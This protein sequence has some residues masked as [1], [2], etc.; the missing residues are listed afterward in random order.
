MRKIP[1]FPIKHA[2][3][4]DQQKVE[5]L[6]LSDVTDVRQTEDHRFLLHTKEEKCYEMVITTDHI[7]EWISLVSESSM[8]VSSKNHEM[9]PN[10]SPRAA[11]QVEAQRRLAHAAQKS[12]FIALLFIDLDRMK[13]YNDTLGHETGDLILQEFALRLE[14]YIRPYD[15]C[16]HFSGDQFMIMLHDMKEL[17]PVLRYASQLLEICNSPL[18]LQDRELFFTA[19]IGISLYSEHGSELETLAKHADLALQYAKENG[20]N[21]FYLYQPEMN[22]RTLERLTIETRLR[23]ALELDELSLEYQPLFSIQHDRLIG[24]EALLRWNPQGWRNVQPSE[25]IPL[26]EETGLI[27]PIGTWVLQEACRQTAEWVKQ[28]YSLE[29]SVN[30]SLQQIYQPDFVSIVQ[31]ALDESGLS[32]AHLCLE[33]TENAASRN[34]SYIIKTVQALKEIGV[35]IFIDDFGTGYSSLSYIK[36]FCADTIKIDRSF[37]ENLSDDSENTAIVKA[38]ITMFKSLK[39]KTLAEGVETKKQLDFLR[40]H[41]CDVVQGYY[42]SKP[43]SVR[44]FEKYRDR[45]IQR[46]SITC[47]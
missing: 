38:L 35:K 22:W 8:A 24:M 3:H 20:G 28:D 12:Q 42:Y 33:V 31:S 25:F 30:I 14:R 41:G 45:H 1:V 47:S 4:P 5:M 39:I 19:S 32:P 7:K 16:A 29:V 17:D 46:S 11:F 23:K 13:L 15:M 26:A 10:L 27:I 44:E 43:L 40:Q 6:N 21:T 18:K 37:I 36:Q 2:Q 9:F 34:L